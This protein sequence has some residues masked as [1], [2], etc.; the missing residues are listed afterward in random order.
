[1]LPEYRSPQRGQRLEA[2]ALFFKATWD[3]GKEG[4]EATQ[5]KFWCDVMSG[6]NIGNR[7][8]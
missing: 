2:S 4:N 3:Q 7:Q 5:G 6:L 8:C 1:M